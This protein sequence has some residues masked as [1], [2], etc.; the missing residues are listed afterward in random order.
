MIRI[1]FI[2]RRGR[3][4][5]AANVQKEMREVGE[6]SSYERADLEKKELAA[7]RTTQINSITLAEGICVSTKSKK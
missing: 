4:V 1:K 3:Q 5:I 6:K 7:N 2:L